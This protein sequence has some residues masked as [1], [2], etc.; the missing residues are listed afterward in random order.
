MNNLLKDNYT[1][2]N[3]YN[4]IEIIRLDIKSLNNRGLDYVYCEFGN[5]ILFFEKKGQ[6]Y[7]LFDIWR[8]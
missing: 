3:F 7:I 5:K 2:G 6:D 1:V 4:E 8:E